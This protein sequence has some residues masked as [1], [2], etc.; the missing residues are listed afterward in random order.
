MKYQDTHFHLDLMPNPIEI[1][2]QI[3]KSEVYTIAVTN[4]PEVFF[5]L[6]TLQRLPGT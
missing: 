1:V 3:E 5:I 6:K 2:K 4:S